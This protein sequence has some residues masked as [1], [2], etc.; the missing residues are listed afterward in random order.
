MAA[1]RPRIVFTPGDDTL[2][3][4][5]RIAAIQDRPASAVVS[6]MM[7]VITPFMLDMVE[8]LEAAK[9]AETDAKAAILAAADEAAGAM[10]PHVAEVQETFWKLLKAVHAA[11]PPSSNTGVTSFG[12][13][14][15]GRA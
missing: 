13:A 6:E 10:R 15:R 14:G 5:Q 7:D 2:A 3:A 4:V 12:V 11:E 9:A 8:A 1:K